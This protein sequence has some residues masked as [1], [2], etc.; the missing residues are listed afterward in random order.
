MDGVVTDTASVHAAA[1]KRLFDDYLRTYAA[2]EGGEFRAFDAQA[3]YLAFVDGK[4][5]YDGVSSFLQ[6]RGIALPF[7]EPEDGPDRETIC[8]LGNRKD[9]YFND[10]LS[11]NRARAF[12]GTVEFIELLRT[13]GIR[14][15]IFSSS[16]NMDAVLS[17]AGVD[18]LFEL[19]VDGRTMSRL[20]LPG[21]PDPAILNTAA[22]ELGVAIDRC[23]VVEDA[24]AGVQ[25]GRRGNCALVIGID[26]GAH[27]DTLLEQG[28]D[29]VVN[30]LSECRIDPHGNIVINR[31]GGLDPVWKRSDAIATVLGERRL[32]VLLDYDGTLTPIVSD[33]R[34]A[35]LA[36][37]VRT[38]LEKLAAEHVVAVISGRDLADVRQ[39]VGL[40]SVYYS[41]SH[42]FELAGPGDWSH[43]QED[44]A[45]YLP[46]LDQAEQTLGAMLAGVPGH[47]IERKRFSVAVHYRQVDD[48][49]AGDVEQAVNEFLAANPRL[50][51]GLGKKVFELKPALDWDKGRAVEL[52]LATLG[53]TRDN[54]LALY[55]GDDVTD[56][57]VFRVLRH[58]HMSIVI[59]DDDRITSANYTLD[60]C[61]D[62]LG[63]LNWLSD[64]A[65]GRRT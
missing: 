44:A 60:D 35:F 7:G 31:T 25:A 37:A 16:R 29:L 61:D 46:D 58:P 65:K 22:T 32:A 30:D 1:W 48:A 6:S 20:D 55:V 26:R 40:D 23:V 4:P 59:S 56:E 41:G 53:M 34:K 33:Y 63:F 13:A 51:K 43:T 49:L 54:S 21:K 11:R 17:S 8:G 50:I 18:A 10:W 39:L 36:D 3:E 47:A 5:R 28:A 27:A 9:G 57:A 15:G 45:G 19:R 52:L 24:I 42:G 64:T 62:V 12:P 38:A 14:V 2:G